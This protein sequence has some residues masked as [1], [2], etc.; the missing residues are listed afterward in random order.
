MRASL[1][2]ILLLT[3]C[4]TNAIDATS[5]QTHHV[6]ETPKAVTTSTEFLAAQQLLDELRQRCPDAFAE[7][8][9]FG[10]APSGDAI[11]T[12]PGIRGDWPQFEITESGTFAYVN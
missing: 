3:A 1:G 4:G 12:Q 10:Q 9:K 7:K 5:A 2:A 6:G 11:V 8:T